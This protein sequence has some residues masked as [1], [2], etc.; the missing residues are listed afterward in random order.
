M[1]NSIKN[2]LTICIC[3]YN[4]ERYIEQTLDGLYHQTFRDFDLL[5]VNDCSTDGTVAAL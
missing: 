4:A 2:E 1:G 5:I 3:A